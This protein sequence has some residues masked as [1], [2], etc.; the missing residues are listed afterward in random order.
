MSYR[1]GL[2]STHSAVV[3][4]GLTALFSKL[5]D[6][7]AIEITPL[8][9]FF[10]V[11]ALL[12]LIR[13]KRQ[14][15]A[16]N[17][18]ADYGWMFL[19]GGLLAAHWAT[20]FHSMQVST[21]AVGVIALYTYPV[22]TVFVEPLFDGERPQWRD[23][24]SA[25]VVFIGVYLMV[26][27]FDI[28]NQTVQGVMWG[29]VSAF[30]FALRNVLQKKKMAAYS[31]QQ[32]LFYQVLV[33][34]VLL[35]PIMIERLPEV[36]YHQWWLLFL[37]GVF[38]T[39]LPHMLFLHGLR[40]L[41][42]KTVSLIACLQVVHATLLA[43]L[44]LGEWPGVMVMCGGALVLLAAIYESYFARHQFVARAGNPSNAGQQVGRGE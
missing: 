4:L 27:A 18:A 16:L 40:L 26:P 25:V 9:S 17:R 11:L 15:L 6:L 36:T 34:L 19:L 21:I 32:S 14:A 3:L 37:L 23:V 28:N 12:L 2:L 30:L 35:L 33:V 42:A 5:I 13:W 22:I 41:K 24:L 38:F 8:R 20:Y 1:E 39:A 44:L 7:P 29:V 43:A 10:A 31:A